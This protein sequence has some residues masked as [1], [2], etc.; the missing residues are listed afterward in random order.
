VWGLNPDKPD[1]PRVIELVHDGKKLAGILIVR[2]DEKGPLRLQLQPW[3]A[4]TGRLLMSKG[5]PVT[6][7]AVSCRAGDAFTDKTGRFRIE[8]L[9]PGRRYPLYF[10][11]EDRGLEIVGGKPKNV[12]V[13]AG[14]TKDLGDVKVKEVE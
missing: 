7:A 8:G 6:G 14:E 1:R 5:E 11:K 10:S 2:G 4:L 13:E 3:G 12:R 9:T